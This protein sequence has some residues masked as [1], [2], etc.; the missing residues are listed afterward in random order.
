MINKHLVLRGEIA[1]QIPEEDFGRQKYHQ[2]IE[3]ALFKRI[4]W[5]R[6]RQLRKPVDLG[7]TDDAQ[8]Y[9]IVF[10]SVAYL[11]AQ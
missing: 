11:A 5:D 6:L 9:N 4:F 2:E 3:V 8:C 1:G 10:Q 7:S